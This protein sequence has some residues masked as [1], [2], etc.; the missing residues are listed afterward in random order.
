M[1]LPQTLSELHPAE[2]YYLS[3]DTEG[4]E[5]DV[6]ASVDFDSVIRRDC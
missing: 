4:N 1:P 3:I 6:L 2:V 5:A